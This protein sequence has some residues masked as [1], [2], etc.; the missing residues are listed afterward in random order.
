MTNKKIGKIEKKLSEIQKMPFEDQPG[1]LEKLGNEVGINLPHSPEYH[2]QKQTITMT[3]AMHSFLQSKMMLNACA[4]SK[5]SCFWASIAATLSL[6][7]SVAAWLTVYVCI[8][9]LKK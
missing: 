2:R 3:Q 4:S 6:F 1:E 7:C 8:L 5:K 9:E